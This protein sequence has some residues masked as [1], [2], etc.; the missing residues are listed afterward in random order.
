[1]YT[2]FIKRVLS[3]AILLYL[4]GNLFAQYNICNDEISNELEDF[5]QRYQKLD[6]AKL[7][8]DIDSIVQVIPDSCHRSLLF[9]NIV[10]ARYHK[11]HSVYEKA[12]QHFDTAL[13][14]SKEDPNNKYT[15]HLLSLRAIMKKVQG[16]SEKAFH[17]LDQG[18]AIPCHQDS[19]HCQKYDIGLRINKASML[20]GINKYEE[21]IEIF[22]EGEQKMKSFGFKDSIYYVSLYTGIGNIYTNN[23]T[24]HEKALSYRRKCLQYMP[25][26]HQATYRVYNNLGTCFV[27]LMNYDSAAYYYNKTIEETKNTR[28]L[29][30]PYQGI[31]SI[32]S[33]KKNFKKAIISYQK[34]LDV[35]SSLGRKR[36]IQTSRGYLG[37]ALY[38]DGQ[39]ESAH[40]KFEK[41]FNNIEG[42]DHEDY[43]L[44]YFKRYAYLSK[45]SLVDPSLSNDI[46]KHMLIKDSLSNAET[47]LK[48]DKSS[49]RLLEQI[50]RDSVE[51]Q[52]LLKENEAE[53]VKNYRLS[54]ALLISGLL[55]LGGLVYQFRSRFIGQKE[56][57][58]DLVFQNQEL[59]LMN[60]RLQEKTIALSKQEISTNTEYFIKYESNNNHVKIDAHR[61]Q[62]ILAEADGIRVFYDDTSNW[63]DM[64][65]KSMQEQLPTNLFVQTFRG[66]VVNVH[67]VE[68]VNSTTLKLKNGKELRVGRTYKKKI[69]E[70]FM[71]M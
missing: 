9:A 22:L 60:K 58:E 6:K 44:E 40:N 71:N 28:D 57:N 19:L 4:S 36:Y 16:E 45:V 37:K 10:L 59:A 42:Y 35:A 12:D 24:D 27:A 5:Y 67:H 17:I 66:I 15:K 30:V 20:I 48:M 13:K 11:D 46:Y 1:M 61:V 65:L 64:T 54:T 26:G 8:A 21:A 7:K 2:N 3:I 52:V 23:I 53:K 43:E 18:I 63:T 31:G 34:A 29:I 50:L 69:K 56:L 32:E 33:Q 41:I 70:A 47:K 62:Y 49:G 39:Y 51:M 55:L 38:L 68:R 25:K 14:L